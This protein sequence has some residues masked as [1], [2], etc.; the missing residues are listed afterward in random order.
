MRLMVKAYNGMEKAF[1][2]DAEMPIFSIEKLL[3]RKLL[4]C[5]I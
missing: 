5:I 1:N 3:I 2:F 4:Q